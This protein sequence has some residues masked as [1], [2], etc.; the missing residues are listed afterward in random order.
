MFPD[1]HLPASV[2]CTDAT[3]PIAPVLSVRLLLI[4][5][6]LAV[7]PLDSMLALAGLV[8]S[9]AEVGDKLVLARLRLVS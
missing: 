8:A 4:A 5:A 2:Q 6:V 3:T 9:D 7:G 1:T